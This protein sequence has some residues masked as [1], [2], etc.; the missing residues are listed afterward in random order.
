M[1]A[2]DALWN[3]PSAH[4]VHVEAPVELDDPVEQAEQLEAPSS[5]KKP[6][7][8]GMGAVVELAGQ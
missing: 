1:E 8:H 7:P 5:L 4:D 3:E 2:P 6:A